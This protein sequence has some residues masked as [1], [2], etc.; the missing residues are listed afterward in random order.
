MTSAQNFFCIL[1][2][3]EKVS[4]VIIMCL[5]EIKRFEFEFELHYATIQFQ[6][7]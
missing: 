5:S 1:S 3:L 7:H 2:G 6:F 4:I